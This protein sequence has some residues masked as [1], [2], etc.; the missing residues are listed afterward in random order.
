VYWLAS[1]NNASLDN[2]ALVDSIWWQLNDDTGSALS[3][4]ALPTTFP[5]LGDWQ[6]N[7]L[8]I[9]GDRRYGIKA[10]VTSAIPEPCTVLLF[11]VGTLFLRKRS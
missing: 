2:G 8:G 10:H 9:E 4:D 3:S 7:V 5:F 6:A 11:G 1:Y